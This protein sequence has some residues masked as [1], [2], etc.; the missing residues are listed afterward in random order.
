MT[1][2]EKYK[3]IFPNIPPFLL[4]RALGL[5][6]TELHGGGATEEW[7]NNLFNSIKSKSETR[8]SLVLTMVDFMI[9]ENYKNMVDLEDTSS[10]EL[11]IAKGR[12]Q[13]LE[14][15]KVIIQDLEKLMEE[16]E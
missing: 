1:P 9:D 10:E 12:F 16:K 7:F 14:A 6:E 11:L 5:D 8:L 15:V 3:K 4:E 2:F 13:S